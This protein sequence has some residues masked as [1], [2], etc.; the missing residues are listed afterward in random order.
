VATNGML[1]DTALAAIPGGR[2]RRD[3][4]G[5]WNAMN[6]DSERRYG[7]T[8]RPLGPLSSYRTLVQQRQLRREWTAKGQPQNAAVPG[9]SN[10]G[11]GLAVD[12]ASQRIR[13]V[14]D[15][16]GQPYGYSKA[17]SDAPWEW[18]HLRYT[19]GVW[20][21]PIVP[22]DPPIMRRGQAG[23]S[24]RRLQRRLRARGFKSV[25]VT[26]YFGIA[27]LRAVRRLQD[28]HRLVVDGIVGPRTWHV[29]D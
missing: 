29:L 28:R 7:V 15:Q 3:A 23:P 12:V 1:P 11:W 2:L 17:W 26:G 5:A 18:W 21:G 27:T 4:A 22:S 16:I 19:P 24:V 13:W 9:T 20:H 6:A 14:I 25:A 10:H 8:L